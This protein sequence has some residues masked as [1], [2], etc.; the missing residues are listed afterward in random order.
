[1]NS[2]VSAQVNFFKKQGGEYRLTPFRTPPDSYCNF[3]KTDDRFYP[4]LA[5]ASDFPKE[6]TCPLPAGTYGLRSY[7][8]SVK[9]VS[10]LVLTTGDYMAEMNLGIGKVEYLKWRIY[11][12]IIR[13]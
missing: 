4:A 8:P 11:A 6:G 10:P 2:S 9:N 13:I 1:M 5:E 3:L 7:A 12:I